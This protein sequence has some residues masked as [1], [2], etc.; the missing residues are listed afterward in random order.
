MLLD[1]QKPAERRLSVFA[2][3]TRRGLGS[4]G[5]TIAVALP[6]TWQRS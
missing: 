1:L 6:I 5:L 3:P 2:E 4:V